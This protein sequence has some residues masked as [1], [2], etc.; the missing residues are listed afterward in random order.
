MGQGYALHEHRPTRDGMPLAE[1]FA[2]RIPVV[3][4]IA[5]A[6]PAAAGM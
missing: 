3:P 6:I 2:A 1:G 4:A 5:A